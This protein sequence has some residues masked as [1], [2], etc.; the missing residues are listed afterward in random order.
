MAAA[1]LGFRSLIIPNA[2][3]QEA[4]YAAGAVRTALR[5]PSPPMRLGSWAILRPSAFKFVGIDS[6]RLIAKT[7][8]NIVSSRSRAYASDAE[9][10]IVR[11]H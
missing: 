1:M 11:S 5:T 6:V 7:L 9:G 4:Q 8:C 2:S 10:G 3:A